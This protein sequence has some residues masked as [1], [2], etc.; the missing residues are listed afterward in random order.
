MIEKAGPY[1]EGI[2]AAHSVTSLSMAGNEYLELER[3]YWWMLGALREFPVVWGYRRLGWY[4]FDLISAK[5]VL[6]RRW[7]S[8]TALQDCPRRSEFLL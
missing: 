7:S 2:A 5:R 4:L 3:E 6:Q 1:Q 8:P